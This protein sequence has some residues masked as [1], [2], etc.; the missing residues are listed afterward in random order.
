MAQ[1]SRFSLGDVRNLLGFLVAGFAGVLNVLGL[2]SA[3]VGVVLR[4][5]PFQ[6]SI[7]SVFLLLAVLVAVIS[8]C[9]NPDA[10]L[11]PGLVAL[12]VLFLTAA[13]FPLLVWVIPAPFPGHSAEHTASIW[14]TWGLLG[15][16][17][18]AVMLHPIT[19]RRARDP[20]VSEK[21]PDPPRAAGERGRWLRKRG[22]AAPV[23]EPPAPKPQPSRWADLL[24][25]QCVLL[26]AAVM[27]TSSAAYGALRVETISQTSTVAE[28]G[29][30]LL[31]N[32]QDDTLSIAVSASKLARLDWLGVNMLAV[33][34]SWKL[35]TLCHSSTVRRLRAKYSVQCLQDPCLYATRVHRHPHCKELSEDVIAPDSTGEVRRTIEVSFAAGK[36]QHVQVTARTCQP[37]PGKGPRGRCLPTGAVSRLDI[38][39]PAPA[40]T[41]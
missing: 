33:P 5:Q 35:A 24:N 4:N 41:K 7:V 2:K 8:I 19:R 14:V 12:S 31:M 16:A 30:T 32:G 37:P 25:L 3:E 39:V 40:L 38:A 18:V 23:P 29:D 9:V 15:A 6:V 11:V 34:R 20:A 17:A 27:L 21:A 13:M 28:I 1:N 10:H 36:F 26:G 22:D